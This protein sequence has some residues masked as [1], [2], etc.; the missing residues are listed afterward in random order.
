MPASFNC[1]CRW[2]IRNKGNEAPH[3][4]VSGDLLVLIE[5]ESHS[6][7]MWE[8]LNVH[9]DLYISIPNAILGCDIEV[10]TI[11]GKAKIK[12]Q[13]GV[14]SRKILRLKSKGVPDIESNTKGD[15]LIHINIW[16]PGKLTKEQMNYFE[17]HIDSNEFTPKPKDQKSFF[18]KVKEMF[19]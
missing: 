13:S 18:E 7:L 2:K 14:Q 15:L 1:T 10:P 17:T 4:G 11:T 6:K 16:T 9:Y 8:G 12:I 19:N 3:E 5:E